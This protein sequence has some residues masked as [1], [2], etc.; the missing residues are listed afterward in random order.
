MRSKATGRVGAQHSPNGFSLLSGSK[1]VGHATIDGSAY[2]CTSRIQI[3]MTLTAPA[4]FG[5]KHRV[6]ARNGNIRTIACQVRINTCNTMHDSYFSKVLTKF[7]IW[8]VC[9]LRIGRSLNVV[10]LVFSYQQS[11]DKT[12]TYPFFFSLSLSVCLSVCLCVVRCC[13]LL[14]HGAYGPCYFR[15]A[16][17]HLTLF[18]FVIHSRGFSCCHPKPL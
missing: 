13:F 2:P 15:G 18:T 10:S 17:Y 5:H 7:Q 6:R 14:T 3:I 1:V 8:L 12:N 4:T 11:F 16:G 9:L